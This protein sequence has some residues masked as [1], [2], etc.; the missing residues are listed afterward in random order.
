MR[1]ALDEIVIP[2]MPTRKQ[3][4]EILGITYAE[5]K[6]FDYAGDIKRHPSCVHPVKYIGSSVR[7]FAMGK[8]EKH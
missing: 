2:P 6:R 4:C 5:L 3:V 7:D 1:C 8:V